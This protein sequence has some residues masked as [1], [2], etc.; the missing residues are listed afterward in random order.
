MAKT[1]ILARERRIALG[2]NV[3]RK[4]AVVVALDVTNGEL[5]FQGPRLE[6]GSRERTQQRI[7]AP[8]PDRKKNWWVF[9]QRTRIAECAKRHTPLCPLTMNIADASEG[10]WGTPHSHEH[11]TQEHTRNTRRETVK[12][13]R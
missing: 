5:L 4:A 8:A 9:P 7:R 3:D 6:S 12:R 11:V 1:K 10:C 2:L 13:L